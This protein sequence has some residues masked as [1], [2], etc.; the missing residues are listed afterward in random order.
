MPSS[1]QWSAFCGRCRLSILAGEIRANYGHSLVGRVEYPAEEP[2]PVLWHGT[3]NRSLAGIVERGILPMK[4]QYVHLTLDR[5]LAARIGARHGK[6]CIVKV[7]AARAHAE[8][9]VFYRA[10]DSFW[11]ANEIA[12]AYLQ[13]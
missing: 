6:A 3:S 13:L 12:A 2:P 4:R 10:N 1:A 5:E 8:G 7:H 11:L 9:V